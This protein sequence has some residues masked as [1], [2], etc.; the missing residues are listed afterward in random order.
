M[1]RR[2]QTALK[3]LEG[4]YRADRM[5]TEAD[6][7]P[8][9]VD[10]V[11]AALLSDE[12][13]AFWTYYSPRLRRLGLLSEIDLHQ[14]IRLCNLWADIC[15]IRA[16]IRAEQEAGTSAGDLKDETIRLRETEKLFHS[17]AGRFGLDP[18]TRSSIDVPSANP[19]ADPAESFLFG[20]RI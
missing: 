20:R 5:K 19:E 9:D 16:H 11:P 15:Q 8:L 1:P 13:R 14:F 10:E 2:R 7:D 6:P 4:T 18:A 17:L 3:L 12:A